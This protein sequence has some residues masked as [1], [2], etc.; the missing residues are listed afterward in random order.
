MLAGQTIDGAC[1]SFTV[2]VKVHEAGLPLASLT[3]QATVVT[4]LLK[5]EP[6][7]GVQVTVP[8]LGQL[9]V[10]VGV[11]KVTAAE[12]C[13]V[14]AGAM[15]LPGQAI[16]GACVSFTVTVK[17]QLAEILAPSITMQVTV[18]VPFEK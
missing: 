9:S 13:L 18:V 4:P 15:M 3:E 7:A 17:E 8:T 1:V 10:A 11:V 16:D 6:L 14:A 5:V 2:T 12:H